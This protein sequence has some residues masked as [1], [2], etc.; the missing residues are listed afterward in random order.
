[1]LYIEGNL[2]ELY[3]FEDMI[4]ERRTEDQ[5]EDPYPDFLEGIFFITVRNY[6]AILCCRPNKQ[7]LRIAIFDAR[8]FYIFK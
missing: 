8:S 6:K 3:K 2:K 7:T 5:Y 1:M 4:E